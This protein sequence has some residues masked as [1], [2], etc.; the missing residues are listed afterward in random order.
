LEK[1]C[2]KPQCAS[3]ATTPLRPEC[4]SH[5]AVKAIPWHC[6]RTHEATEQKSSDYAAGY[7][8][9]AAQC[10]SAFEPYYSVRG[11]LQSLNYVDNNAFRHSLCLYPKISLKGVRMLAKLLYRMPS[12]CDEVGSEPSVNALLA[13]PVFD[14]HGNI[15]QRRFSYSLPYGCNRQGAQRGQL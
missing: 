5:M 12:N 10:G 8:I 14:L 11:L 13:V 6:S 3:N 15:K 7:L 2:G 4:V 1:S 9:H